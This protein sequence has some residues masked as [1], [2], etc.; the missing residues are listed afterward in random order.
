MFFLLFFVFLLDFP[1]I[2]LTP[3]L[4]DW[5]YVLSRCLVENKCDQAYDIINYI[6]NEQDK[7]IQNSDD[8]INK[9]KNFLLNIIDTLSTEDLIK[10]RANYI[11]HLFITN[12]EQSVD[13]LFHY[14]LVPNQL[15][16]EIEILNVLMLHK[17]SVSNYT[18][19]TFI[20]DHF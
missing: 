5:L 17:C 10:L 7:R 6:I 13:Q 18:T 2:G 1:S 14:V 9:L 15:S 3:K 20:Y 16:H 19:T 11:D 4:H 8:D 12:K